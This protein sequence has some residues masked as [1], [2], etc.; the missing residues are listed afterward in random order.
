MIYYNY[1]YIY[2]IYISF[3]QYFEDNE[4]SKLEWIHFD[5]WTLA[6]DGRYKAATG[7]ESLTYKY[8]SQY[9]SNIYCNC[10]ISPYNQS[11]DN[12]V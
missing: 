12:H 2:N 5:R 3:L 8:V 10:L 1:M 7:P 4:V 6:K 11:T 9:F